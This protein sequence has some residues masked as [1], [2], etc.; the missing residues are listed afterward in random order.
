M[1]SSDKEDKPQE[2]NNDVTTPHEPTTQNTNNPPPP[3]TQSSPDEQQ[4]LLLH[5]L[6]SLEGSINSKVTELLTLLQNHDKTTK[7]I[8]KSHQNS[9]KQSV[10]TQLEKSHAEMR[11]YVDEALMDP[12]LAIEMLDERIKE[13]VDEGIQNIKR[14][15]GDGGWIKRESWG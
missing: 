13:R 5:Q 8:L 12:G 2:P 7:Q 3:S 14:E 1:S 9:V 11:K 10:R 15:G 6:Q 4:T